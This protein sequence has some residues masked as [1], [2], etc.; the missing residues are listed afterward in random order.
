MARHRQ[1][2]LGEEIK[3]CLSSF[4]INGVKDPRLANRIIT[5]SGVDVTSD[6]SYAYVYVTPLVLSGE[7]KDAVCEEVL[8]GFNKA[9]GL[10]RNKVAS[11]IKLRYTPELIFNIDSSMDYGRHIDSILE[12]IKANTPFR[13]EDVDS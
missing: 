1:G 3:K 11:E 2:R 10:L 7:D 12:E 13:E 6:G 8:A 5:I 4:L 9:K